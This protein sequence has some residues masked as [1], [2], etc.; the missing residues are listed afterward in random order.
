MLFRITPAGTLTEL[1][2]FCAQSGCPDGSAPTS[3]LVQYTDGSF[4]GTAR[5]GGA[6]DVGTVFTL[7]VGLK[8]FVKTVPASGAAGTFVSILGS[9]LS[10]ATS[11]TFA[12][13]EA[14]FEVVSQTEITTRVPMGATSGT[15]HVA[16]SSG[17]LASNEPFVVIP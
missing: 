9:D 13:I 7:A 15:V 6:D 4:Y 1:H 8:P 12:G 14:E 3:A 5:N 10:S 2:A 17:M 11:V 16:V